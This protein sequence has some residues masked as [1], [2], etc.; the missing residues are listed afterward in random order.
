MTPKIHSCIDLLVESLL[1]FLSFSRF[2]HQCFQHSSNKNCVGVNPQELKKSNLEEL[3][4]LILFCAEVGVEEGMALLH[5][6]SEDSGEAIPLG[7]MGMAAQPSV[8]VVS[9]H[10]F[11]LQ[12]QE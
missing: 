6:D 1:G 12:Y 8:G 7:D 2:L 4:S 3:Y 10:F 11:P 9:M 5:S